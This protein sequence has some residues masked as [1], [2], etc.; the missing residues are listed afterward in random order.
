MDQ[1]TA[2]RRLRSR[3][4]RISGKL[5]EID[6]YAQG[7]QVPQACERLLGQSCRPQS[8][9]TIEIHPEAPDPVAPKIEE[10]HV[11]RIDRRTAALPASF[12]P[13]KHKHSVAEIAELLRERLELLPV[14]TNIRGVLFDALASAVA[15]A[16]PMERGSVGSR[17]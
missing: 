11:L 15:P 10:A 16:A 1:R 13:S 17:H 4:I 7:W 8:F 6:G 12:E 9:G 2:A 5:T 14:P 3:G